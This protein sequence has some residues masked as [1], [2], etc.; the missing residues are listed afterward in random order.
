MEGVA[1]SPG[2]LRSF[3]VIAV[4]L[5]PTLCNPPVC[6]TPG[7]PVL[8]HL[9]AFCSNSWPLSWRCHLV[10][11][12]PLLL[13]PSVFPS[14][15]VF[16]YE[17]ALCIRW[18]EYW[19]FSFSI[20]APNEYSELISFRIDWFDLLVVQGP[21]KNLLQHHNLKASVLKH[22][23]FFMVQLL[24]I[25]MTTGKTIALATQ[26]FVSKVISLLFNTLS[27]L[28]IAFLPRIWS[29]G[30]KYFLLVFFQCISVLKY[31]Q[32][33]CHMYCFM[34]ALVDLY[35]IWSVFFHLICFF[36]KHNFEFLVAVPL[37][38]SSVTYHS[39]IVGQSDINPQM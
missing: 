8:H 30:L 27:R 5:G 10:L 38:G 29:Y 39:P 24:R 32:N 9:T 12:S 13:L 31:R 20:S 35:I 16:S 18:P 1:C 14:I 34:V 26:T 7:F 3:V 19:S 4:Q 6:S 2:I 33:W 25:Y 17:S 15:R 28:V 23:A 37:D 21:L 36:L 22:S 11:C